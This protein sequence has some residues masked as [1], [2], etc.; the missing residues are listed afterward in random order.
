MTATASQRED[1]TNAA[2]RAGN[3]SH[4][5]VAV[6]EARRL[7]TDLVDVAARDHALL[8]D[9]VAALTAHEIETIHGELVYTRLTRAS[10]DDPMLRLVVE[11]A[12]TAHASTAITSASLVEPCLP[13]ATADFRTLGCG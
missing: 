1:T 5:V 9:A 7:I 3:R 12:I 13:C 4:G 2:D 8:H 10:V 6:A 11:L